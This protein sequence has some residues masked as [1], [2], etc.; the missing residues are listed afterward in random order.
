[1]EGAEYHTLLGANEIIKKFKPIMAF[2]FGKAS[3]SA[4]SVNPS[5]VYEYFE[6]LNYK[7]YSIYGDL[8]SKDEFITESKV[9]NFWDYIA[10]PNNK[11]AKVEK[12]FRCSIVDNH[13]RLEKLEKLYIKILQRGGDEEGINY[14]N[15][16]LIKKVT[17]FDEIENLMR[18]SQEYMGL[19]K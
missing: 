14:Y 15:Q 5:D 2:E 7:I 1:M 13:D 12:T 8:L 17:T 6:N 4:Y 10:S 11:V 3:Y 19:H 16:R 9:Q 18:N